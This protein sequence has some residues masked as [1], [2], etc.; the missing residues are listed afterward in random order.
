MLDS[1]EGVQALHADSAYGIAGDLFIA[2]D[3]NGGRIV[4][5]KADGSGLSEL[6]GADANLQKPEGLAFGDFNAAALPALYAAENAGGRVVR[7]G[8][9]G[10]VATF[11]NP[12][13]IGGLNGPD[14]IEFGPDGFLYVGE[15]YGGRIVRIAADGTHSVLASG[16]DNIE[17]VAF[18]PL[19]GDLYVGEIEKSSIWR[20]RFGTSNAGAPAIALQ[21]VATGLSGPVDIANARDGSGRLFIVQQGGKSGFSAQARYCLRR[22]WIFNPCLSGCL[23]DPLPVVC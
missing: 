12:A 14:N 6:V 16:F 9:D 17:G 10:S 20:V 4:R 15:K 8:A 3:R 18:D 21:S 11:G 22:F 5:V 13:G 2:E 23:P 7:I 19:T 1:P